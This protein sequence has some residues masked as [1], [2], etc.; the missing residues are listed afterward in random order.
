MNFR[1]H[2]QKVSRA[3]LTPAQYTIGSNIDPPFTKFEALRLKHDGIGGYD[4]FVNIDNAF[5][6]SELA[7]A[8]DNDKPL[9]K[10]RF[11]WGL[12]LAAVGMLRYAKRSIKNET[13]L[14]NRE[15]SDEEDE[16]RD[17]D[18][19]ELV[20]RACNGLAQVVIPIIRSLYHAPLPS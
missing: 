5:L 8:K 6:V 9:M 10:H 20:N 14:N 4:Y 12:V 1:E 13:T 19:T 18:D 7:H 15:N 17:N 16:E 11:M 2:H 3:N